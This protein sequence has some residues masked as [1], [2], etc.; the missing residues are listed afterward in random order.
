MNY[1]LLVVSILFILGACQVEQQIVS[2]NQA[3]A[4]STPSLEFSVTLPSSGRK[5]KDSV[6]SISLSHSKILSV[7]GTPYIKANVNGF[8]KKFNYTSGS[9]T[10]T[11]TFNYTVA[12]TDEDQDGVEINPLIYLNNGSIKYLDELGNLNNV[13]LELKLPAYEIILDGSSPFL[14][15][16]TYPGP[17][18]YK[19]GD[20]LNYVL[21]FNESVIVKSALALNLTLG[22][23]NSSFE[24]VSGSNSK[25]VFFR[26]KIE[27]TDLDTDG[28]IN[29]SS[30][31][32]AT[33]LTDLAGNSISTSLPSVNKTGVYINF[34]TPKVIS[35]SSIT[36]PLNNMYSFGQALEF[37]VTFSSAILVTGTPYLD[38]ILNSGNA[39]AYFINM[40]APETALFRYTPNYGD[41]D[42]TD[43][44]KLGTTI[45]QGTGSI[46]SADNLVSAELT[47]PTIDTSGIKVNSPQIPMTIFSYAPLPGL[48]KSGQTIDIALMFNRPIT[49]DTSGGTPRIPV[50][51][52]NSTV[53]A[54]Y[55]SMSGTQTA[56]FRYTVGT[57]EYDLDGI[58]L[59]SVIEPNGGSIKD[60]SSGTAALYSF[61]TPLTS[62][63]NVDGAKPFVIGVQAPN[64]GTYGPTK[65][66]DFVVN[67]N[68][69]VKVTGTPE[70]KLTIGSTTQSATYI[71]GTNSTS[72]LFRY[73]IQAGDEDTD[74]IQVGDITGGS[75][76]DNYGNIL[77]YPQTLSVV[78]AGIKV[79]GVAPTITNA[80]FGTGTTGN[81]TTGESISLVV[82]F[83]EKVFV[84]GSP[85]INLV[86]GSSI[87]SATYSSI[88]ATGKIITFKYKIEEGIEDLNGIVPA[89]VIFLGNNDSIKD[90]YQNA[91]LLN[92][93]ST[94][95]GT[96]IKV[97]SKAPFITSVTKPAGGFYK[98]G[99]NLDF[100]LNWS[101]PVQITGAPLLKLVIDG[102]LYQ[103]PLLSSTP[104]QSK[105][106]YTVTASTPNSNSIYLETS[107]NLNSGTIK[108]LNGVNLNA[109]T[110]FTSPSLADVI[111]D[112][113]RPK[114]EFISSP[115]LSKTYYKNQ[116]AYIQVRFSETLTLASGPTTGITLNLTVGGTSVEAT[117]D[118]S[119]SSDLVT[120]FKYTVVS[121]QLDTD[122]I[123]VNSITLNG[124]SIKDKAGNSADISFSS[125]IL[126]G[127]KV[128][129]NAGSIISITPPDDKTY[130][131]AEYLDFMVKFDRAVDVVNQP[132]LKLTF[133]GGFR[134]ACYDSGSGSDTLIFRYEVAF[135]ESAANGVTITS[136]L[137][138]TQLTLAATIKDDILEDVNLTF[139]P[140]TKNYPDVKVDSIPI[141]SKGIVSTTGTFYKFQ[142]GGS[143]IY[144]V[145]Y[146]EPM[147]A[148]NSP[149]I[150]LT[151]GANIKYA[152]YFSGSGTTVLK[153]KYDFGTTFTDQIDL[154][155]ITV[156]SPIQQSS[157]F[158]NI[159]TNS[160]VSVLNY[161]LIVNGKDYLY[162]SS[163]IARYNFQPSNIKVTPCGS[164]MCLDSSA[165]QPI[166]DLSGLNNHITT[167]SGPTPVIKAGFG[168]MLSDYAQFDNQSLIQLPEIYGV[169]AIMIVLKTPTDTEII[170]PGK[171]HVLLRDPSVSENIISLR[172]S[173]DYNGINDLIVSQYMTLKMNGSAL[174]F[175]DDNLVITRGPSISTWN[176]DSNYLFHFASTTSINLEAGTVLGGD[177]FN[178]QIAEIL[179]FNSNSNPGTAAQT[180]LKNQ[181]DA[182]H[183][184]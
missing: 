48:Y 63:I 132:C 68:E 144:N 157:A 156:H 39:K 124:G 169:K 118:V 97:D 51:V 158:S 171:E 87:K 139:S 75:I 114:V 79:D 135:N 167:F 140:T 72:L 170:Q 57:T 23:T 116:F 117:Y 67:F 9:G 31:S 25:N 108:D 41:E 6:L 26:K 143:I 14:K 112:T 62:G 113:V 3:T 42:L 33:T 154:D 176:G 104:T 130:E 30:Y 35:S 11:I 29:F 36:K 49:I 99:D 138:L 94:P 7:S 178:G 15:V 152:N 168:S 32:L 56:I 24:Y 4:V 153:F 175:S 28:S 149:R 2:S 163:L 103:L 43:G 131:T 83:S 119:Q 136:P 17:G 21:T 107:L 5:K 37:K 45:H 151:V 65:S 20:V 125:V 100:V 164:E 52:G 109:N 90:P 22:S 134:Y 162:P 77:S 102:Q 115:S 96:A 71:S 110:T 155:G 46:R 133:D 127:I 129:G 148:T 137:L 40:T 18:F 82:T 19:S 70:I 179:F 121:G 44:I 93:P 66:L 101:E 53:Y 120:A 12:A 60:S 74:G 13:S 38:I 54:K 85:Y 47:L 182:I 145:T 92:I 172:S 123:T 81:M 161:P 84:Q 147:L 8:V 165:S 95:D 88:D 150:K 177:S 122:G 142:A 180:I 174:L 34:P 141:A 91:A 159:K 184:Y 160:G 181:L 64:N 50:Y 73:T 55:N 69:V 89:N 27:S 58:N 128:N 173:V 61:V 106:R 80:V 126:S 98:V 146:A 76:Q 1:N 105:F 16:V 111:I 166:K 183:G 59:S 78:S 10:H 86:L